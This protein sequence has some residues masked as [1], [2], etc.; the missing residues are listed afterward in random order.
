MSKEIP[1]WVLNKREYN[2]KRRQEIG[3]KCFNVNVSPQ[4]FDDI[5]RILKEKNMTR[6]DFIELIIKKYK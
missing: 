6:Q 1:R 5:T 3:Y 2:Q 4:Q